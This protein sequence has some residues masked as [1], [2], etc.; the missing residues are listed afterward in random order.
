ML[1]EAGACSICNSPILL[2]AGMGVPSCLCARRGS[3]GSG[4]SAPGGSNPHAVLPKEY[5]DVM[6]SALKE[7]VAAECTMQDGELSSHGAY[8]WQRAIDLIATKGECEII[9]RS[10]PI[11]FAKWL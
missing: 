6:Y 7:I 1:V 8:H 4:I 9:S 11:V 10:G 2:V 5:S 3:K